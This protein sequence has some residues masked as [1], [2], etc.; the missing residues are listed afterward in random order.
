LPAGCALRAARSDAGSHPAMSLARP[1]SARQAQVGLPPRDRAHFRAG[2]A[3][4]G[5]RCWSYARERGVRAVLQGGAMSEQASP[6][7]QSVASSAALRVS[8]PSSV[9]ELDREA[10]E[11][12]S[13]APEIAATP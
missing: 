13:A 12:P 5:G 10:L 3:R 7:V 11:A 9:R 2:A 6:E 1:G 8:S 4:P